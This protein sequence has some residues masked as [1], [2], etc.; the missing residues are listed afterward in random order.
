MHRCRPVPSWHRYVPPVNLYSNGR[1]CEHVAGVPLFN[2]ILVTGCAHRVWF[3]GVLL[4]VSLI[5]GI[6]SKHP[7]LVV[8]IATLIGLH[9]MT[10]MTAPPL[11]AVYPS[12]KCGF[13]EGKIV[14]LAILRKLRMV[15]ISVA[16]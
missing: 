3:D 13:S 11:I 9:L 7:F 12:E 10:W 8:S 15:L 14:A 1:C 4:L 6:S 5:M 2:I 16:H